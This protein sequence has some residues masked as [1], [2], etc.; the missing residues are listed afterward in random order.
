MKIVIYLAPLDRETFFKRFYTV[1]VLLGLPAK[2]PSGFFSL[3]RQR[4]I[5]GGCT[6]PGG[7]TPLS[8]SRVLDPSRMVDPSQTRGSLLTYKGPVYFIN[9]SSVSEIFQF[10]V[11]NPRGEFW[12]ELFAFI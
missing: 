4:T 12:L 2:W 11:G 5:V 7:R 6:P 10:S 1:V 9:S 3:Y 8:K